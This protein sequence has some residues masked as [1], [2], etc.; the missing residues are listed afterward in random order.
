MFLLFL[1]KKIALDE[2]K[3]F[4]LF[5]FPESVS[6]HQQNIYG[7]SH[8]DVSKNFFNITPNPISTI[9]QVKPAKLPTSD[10]LLTTQDLFSPK[11]HDH[12]QQHQNLKVCLGFKP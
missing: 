11:I 3:F 5:S 8:N 7:L 9:K 10:C 2:K 4:G 1:K 12:H 6:P